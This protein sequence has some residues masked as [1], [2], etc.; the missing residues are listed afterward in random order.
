MKESRPNDDP[1]FDRLVDGE[2]N[3]DERRSLLNGL[4]HE[5]GGWRRCALAFLE[6]QCWQES[7][8]QSKAI[9]VAGSDWSQ[10]TTAIGSARPR[11]RWR[12]QARTAL[13]MAACFFLGALLIGSWLP[14][15]GRPNNPLNPP[16]TV[17]RLTSLPGGESA[18]ADQGRGAGQLQPPA[19][20]EGAWRL[21]TLS[22]SDSGDGSPWLEVPA[23]ERPN[24]DETWLR[25]LPPAIPEN[26]VQALQR[27]GHEVRQQREFLPVPMKDGRILVV[28]VDQVDVHANRNP[29]Y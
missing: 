6:A 15:S 27:T 11:G 9:R 25:S 19:G 4:D 22:P 1:R 13:A 21:V 10:P 17:G 28:P 23:R 26:V 16:D 5:P 20:R 12:A 14:R 7:L 29:A 24:L 2:L 3:Q 18:L 8:R